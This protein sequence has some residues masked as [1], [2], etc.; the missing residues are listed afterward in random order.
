MKIKGV[1]SA[2][3][4]VSIGLLAIMISGCFNKTSISCESPKVIIG[5]DCCLD[6]NRNKACDTNETGLCG[7]Q[8]C[9]AGENCTNCWKDCGA[10]KRIIYIYVPRNFT[11]KEFELDMRSVMGNDV[12]FR[13]DIENI[14]NVTDF[15]YYTK[16]ALRYIE[17]VLDVKRKEFRESKAVV[18]NYIINDHYYVNDSESM[19]NY[20]NYTNW[21]LIHSIKNADMQWF[22]DVL[23]SGKATAYYPTQ[24]TG[25]QKE[26]RYVDWEFR[27]KERDSH[28]R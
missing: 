10:C 23:S 2:L 7:N 13:R 16:P 11:L 20:L 26:F 4:V 1:L 9:E 6:L 8:K 18:L 19:F 28:L 21:Y 3:L 25:Y 15:F 17:D 27:N 14:N 24:P 22:E 5:E 12:K